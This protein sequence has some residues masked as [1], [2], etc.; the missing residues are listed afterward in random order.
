EGLKL[1]LGSLT[2][3]QVAVDLLNYFNAHSISLC[4]GAFDMKQFVVQTVPGWTL[5]NYDSSS[6]MKGSG[7][8]VFHDFAADYSKTLTAG[9]GL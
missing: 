4:T 5:T 1:G 3:Y 8:L 2:D 9:D 6:S 7:T